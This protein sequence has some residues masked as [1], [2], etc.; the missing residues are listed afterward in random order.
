MTAF[1]RIWSNLRYHNGGCC[2][3]RSLTSAGWC[4]ALRDADS[5]RLS[6]C[7]FKLLAQPQALWLYDILRAPA[8][9]IQQ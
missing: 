6:R 9:E 2:H 8:D 3:H 1:I 4:L 5:E 7:K